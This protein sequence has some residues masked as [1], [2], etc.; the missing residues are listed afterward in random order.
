MATIYSS[1][2]VAVR[3]GQ[4]VVGFSA[5]PAILVT[6]AEGTPLDSF[7]L[8]A[9]RRR[10]IPPDLERSFVPTLDAEKRIGAASDLNAISFRADGSIIFVH[11]D[12]TFLPPRSV[13]ARI[14]VSVLSADLQTACVDGE[15][16]SDAAE[17]RFGYGAIPC[18]RFIRTRAVQGAERP[19]SSDTWSTPLVVNGFRYLTLR[20]ADP[21]H[22]ETGHPAFPRQ[23]RL[24][25]EQ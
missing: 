11:F 5:D 13:A 25:L 24:S 1:V 10:D 23:N 21:R 12:H 4:L 22:A 18:S 16:V 14:F 7:R 15:L 17:G 19:Q 3:A 9:T 20:F 8:P 2:G 6:D